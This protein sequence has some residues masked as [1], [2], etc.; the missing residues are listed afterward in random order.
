MVHATCIIVILVLFSFFFQAEDCI[1]D[2]PV[3]G[4]QTCALPI[5]HP[6]KATTRM[7]YLPLTEIDDG[8][9][10]LDM[11]SFFFA[12]KSQF[13]T[14]VKRVIQVIILSWPNWSEMHSITKII[15]QISLF[16]TRWLSTIRRYMNIW[17]HARL[18]RVTIT[19][20]LLAILLD[21][22]SLRSEEHTSELQSLVNLVC[23]LLLEK[24]KKNRKKKR[25][26]RE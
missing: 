16:A 13:V 25:K 15:T 14:L 9:S 6:R 5:S 20:W 24:K 3:T 8:V 23:R 11:A 26:K 21:T 7:I 18:K 10:V 17:K 22:D 1:R 4:V 2:S 19:I 12:W